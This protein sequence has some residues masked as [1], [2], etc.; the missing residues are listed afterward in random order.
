MVAAVTGAAAGAAISVPTID[1]RLIGV[2]S[3]HDPDGA[4]I[5][6]VGSPTHLILFWRRENQIRWRADRS[7]NGNSSTSSIDRNCRPRRL[8]WELP[9]IQRPPDR[10]R[11]GN[12]KRRVCRIAHGTL[13]IVTVFD[14]ANGDLPVSRTLRDSLTSS[15]MWTLAFRPPEHAPPPPRILLI[16]HNFYAIQLAGIYREVGLGCWFR[17][18]KN[19]IPNGAHFARACGP[20]AI[21]GPRFV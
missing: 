3:T 20:I 19:A 7:R 14:A 13:K 21:G 17:T 6:C 15:R 2:V 12:R 10:R 9:T 8:R 16:L 1:R 11:R 18:E 5:G 4:K